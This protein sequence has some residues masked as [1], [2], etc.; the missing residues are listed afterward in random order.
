MKDGTIIVSD[1]LKK[2]VLE[3]SRVFVG[4]IDDDNIPDAIISV[5]SYRGYDLLLNEHLIIINIDGKLTLVN[6]MES[7]MK[8]LSL[9]DRIITADVPTH[10]R[11]SPL[12]NCSKCREVVK[13]KFDKGVLVKSE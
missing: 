10:S 6:A 13:Y 3:P 4:P 5:S 7:D 12:F 2:Y 9:K 1:S 11:N 8:I